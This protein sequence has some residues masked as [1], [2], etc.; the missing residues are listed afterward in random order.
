M[1]VT[2]LCFL[3][4]SGATDSPSA[5]NIAV[6]TADT[7]NSPPL[8]RKHTPRPLEIPA[9]LVAA[10]ASWGLCAHVLV[11]LWLWS[12]AVMLSLKFSDLSVVLQ[13]SGDFCILLC[14][15]DWTCD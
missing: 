11:T 4:E 10:D 14:D 9:T 2:R 15:I 13:L 3:D 8:R 5:S 7:E 1:R 12:A 6:D